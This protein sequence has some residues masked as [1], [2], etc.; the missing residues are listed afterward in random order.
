MMS[1]FR[2][3]MIT[4]GNAAMNRQEHEASLTAFYLLFGDVMDTDFAIQRLTRN[5]L[6]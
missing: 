2:T 5:S 4:D 1:N 6:E 3:V